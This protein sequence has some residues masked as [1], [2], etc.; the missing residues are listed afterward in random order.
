MTD[1]QIKQLVKLLEEEMNWGPSKDWK[2]DDF[3][4]LREEIHAKTSVYLSV[5]TLKRLVGK[6]EYEGTP[7]L[8]TLN[9]MAIFLD[10]QNWREFQQEAPAESSKGGKLK[11]IQF[12]MARKF[13]IAGAL[14]MLV[15]I[16]VFS[17]VDLP[18]KQINP[19]DVSFEIERV[20]KGLPNTVIF[21]Y[22]VSNVDAN[23][24][25]IQQDWDPTKRHRVD[26]TKQIFTHFYEYPGYYNAKLLV[27][28][29]V[30][31]TRDLYIPSEGWMAAISSEGQPPRYLLDAEW[32]TEGQL[33]VN[34]SAVQRLELGNDESVL[35]F[36]NAVDEP[37][38]SFENFEFKVKLRFDATSGNN[39]C[40]YR[41]IVFLGSK[42]SMRVPISYKGCVAQ[43][44]LRLGN[45]FVDGET[46]DLSALGVES[47][48]PV[49][50][51]IT[52]K[53]N[54]LSIQ[55]A[56]NPPLNYQLQDDFGNLGGVQLAFHGVGEVL[57]LS[58]VTPD[59]TLFSF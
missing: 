24:V 36:Y 41:R 29:Q 18:S 57:E 37:D 34:E 59:T 49:E 6:V 20:T 15:V 53:D 35:S 3:E 22:D 54:L 56:D 32:V 26:P 44:R 46:N 48:E 7:T 31:Q 14:V 1:S 43:N 50:I 13:F 52:N 47:G 2:T 58:L 42:M 28:G 45:V 9:T 17:F 12:N 51:Q 27:N 39:P 38:Q 8:T 19:E 55:V 33:Q 30:L 5:T 4:S 16:L 40:E 21:K 10:Y 25:Q 23:Q 11:S